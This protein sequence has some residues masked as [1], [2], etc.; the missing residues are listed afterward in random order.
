MSSQGNPEV[1]PALWFVGDQDPEWVV[2]R[3]VRY[4]LRDAELPANWR[5]IGEACARLSRRGNFASVAV[6]SANN[7]FDEDPTSVVPLWRGGPM[8][9]R[10]VGLVSKDSWLQ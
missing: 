9:V 5:A 1:D 3:A 8:I 6:A 7:S 2:V 4:P 10:Y